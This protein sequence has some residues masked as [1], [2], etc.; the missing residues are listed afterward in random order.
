MVAEKREVSREDYLHE[1]A[2]LGVKGKRRK[3]LRSQYMGLMGKI[4]G[5]AR[6]QRRLLRRVP[7][8][9]VVSKVII[10]ERIRELDRSRERLLTQ[11]RYI[12]TTEL[13][14]LEE[15]IARELREFRQKKRPPPPPKRIL[16]RIRIRLYNLERKPTPTGMFQGLFIIDGIVDVETGLV[17]WEFW[18]T[19]QEIDIAKYH[20]IGYWK[21]LAKWRSS[22]Q[23]DLTYFD[24]PEGIPYGTE[25][26]K[27][28][29]S[30]QG[31]PYTK[32][33]P[34]EF[35]AKAEA[36]TIGELIVGE[37]SVE[38]EPNLNPTP[39]N[40]GVFFVEAFAIDADGVVKWHEIR[41]KWIYH[42]SNDIVEKIR[43]ELGI[44]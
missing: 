9:S 12:R 34:A 11:M 35:I 44:E 31:V 23:I 39:K 13:P 14:I 21:G 5:V 4:S 10:Y 8:V 7:Y 36:L 32:N 33:V 6:K 1:R 28:K 20:F 30:G 2:M 16:S 24:S 3:R 41:N 25:M 27:Y 26:V 17:D 40:T 18:L 38:P 15:E 29:R 22:E 43:S 19:K 37:S 42:L